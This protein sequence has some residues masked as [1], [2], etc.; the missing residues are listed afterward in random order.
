MIIRAELMANEGRAQDA[1]AIL[2]RIES[3]DTGHLDRDSTYARERVTAVIAA[4]A[5]NANDWPR[6]RP[7]LRELPDDRTRSL[8]SGYLLRRTNAGDRLLVNRKSLAS[9][10]RLTFWLPLAGIIGALILWRVSRVVESSSLGLAV[11]LVGLSA[12]LFIEFALIRLSLSD[13][14]ATAVRVSHEEIRDPTTS[15]LALV[16]IGDALDEARA[17]RRLALADGQQLSFFGLFRAQLASIA[18]RNQ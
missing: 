16:Q 5:L 18:A 3:L 14:I 11:F 8:L 9:V 7:L 12:I 4:E 2:A 17:G 10:R 15:P 6:A 13:V 1:F